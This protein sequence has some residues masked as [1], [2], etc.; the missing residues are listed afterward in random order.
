M[1]KLFNKVF[2]I[3]DQ[4]TQYNSAREI[5]PE[6]GIS[7]FPEKTTDWDSFNDSLLNFINQDTKDTL[8]S[9]WEK[10]LKVIE[11]HDVDAL[12]IDVELSKM[13]QINLKQLTSDKLNV[14]DT[15]GKKL[16]SWF[17]WGYPPYGFRRLKNSHE[18]IFMVVS[19]PYGLKG[20]TQSQNM[21]YMQREKT[22]NKIQ[23]EI[24]VNRIE[25]M[26]QKIST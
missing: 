20:F 6:L 5:L 14:L 22:S 15:F 11:V 26:L 16:S 25:D 21:T 7:V 23:Y 17:L 24:I 19:A 1:G 4:K 3:E 10:I 2:I 8:M 9:E 18:K 12:L 13:E